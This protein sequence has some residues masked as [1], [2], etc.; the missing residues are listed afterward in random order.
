VYETPNCRFVADFIGDVNLL[1][2]E[3]HTGRSGSL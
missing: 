3:T 1:E 2:G